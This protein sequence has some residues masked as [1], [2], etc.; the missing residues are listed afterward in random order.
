M[1]PARVAQKRVMPCFPEAFTGGEGALGHGALGQGLTGVWGLDHKTTK[2][3]LLWRDLRMLLETHL[4]SG[5]RCGRD[6]EELPFT[7]HLPML[8]I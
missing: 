8:V 2:G 7:K 5:A 4:L 6:R 1:L 3:E